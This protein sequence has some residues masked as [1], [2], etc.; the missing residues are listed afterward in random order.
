MVW[1][2]KLETYL[3][4]PL[5]NEELWPDLADAQAGTLPGLLIIGVHARVLA[6]A[7]VHGPLLLGVEVVLAGALVAAED[8]GL[9]AAAVRAPVLAVWG[10]QGLLA[11]LAAALQVA[12]LAAEVVAGAAVAGASM[13]GLLTAQLAAVEGLFLPVLAV[14][15]AGVDDLVAHVGAWVAGFVGALVHRIMLPCKQRT[16]GIDY[17]YSSSTSSRAFPDSGVASACK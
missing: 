14:L 10:P 1:P 11:A 15:A 4:G 9:R 13:L 5:L 7:E 2:Y 16:L 3:K 6:L 8:A 17:V 12:W